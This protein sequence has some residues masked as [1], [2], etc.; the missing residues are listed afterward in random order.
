MK[1]LGE[2]LIV[3]YILIK[4]IPFTNVL[5]RAKIINFSTI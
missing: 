2:Q 5:K 3:E 1:A 4:T